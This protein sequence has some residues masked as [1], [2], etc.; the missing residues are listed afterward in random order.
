MDPTILC[1]RIH[2]MVRHLPDFRSPG[3][4]RCHDGLYLFY[5]AREESHHAV[6]GRIVRVGNH[7]RSQGSLVRRLRQH[8]SGRKNGSVFRKLLGG[9][10]MRSKDPDDPCLRPGPGKGHWE[11]QDADPCARC[12]PVEA[13]VS[14]RLRT[15]FR[16]KV[17]SVPDM[18]ERNRLEKLLVATLAAC[19]A[20]GPSPAWLG[21]HAYSPQVRESG[22][23]N[24]QFV[25][26]EP[27][28]E[29]EIRLLETVVERTAGNRQ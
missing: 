1:E 8:Y 2:A 28:D 16:F 4:V 7:P 5:E 12:L 19:G 3:D 14:A 24:S 13:E 11:R 29:S 17:L 22:M 9:A 23:W 25:G 6:S 18:G 21:L 10:L 27:M 15:S 26:E 20:C